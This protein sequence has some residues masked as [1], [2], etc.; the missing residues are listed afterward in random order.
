MKRLSLAVALA[1]LVG[2]AGI[3]IP[4]PPGPPS[5]EPG[6][7]PAPT[8]PAGQHLE[9]V[10]CV[11]DAP[12]PVCNTPEYPKACDCW[13][14][15]PGEP[16][17]K[18]AACAGAP[19][20]SLDE[21][22]PEKNAL[23]NDQVSRFGADVL[24]AQGGACNVPPLPDWKTYVKR[25]QAALKA[26]GYHTRYDWEHGG[27]GTTTGGED[28]GTK[29]LGSEIGIWT[30]EDA[31]PGRAPFRYESYQ[32]V[33]TAPK[34][35]CNGFTGAAAVRGG[36][37]PPPPAPGAECAVPASALDPSEPFRAD[38]KPHPPAQTLD[39]TLWGCGPDVVAK[40]DPGH[41]PH[42]SGAHGCL[43][44]CCPFEEDKGT[45]PCADALWG[46]ALWSVEE[47]DAKLVPTANTNTIKVAAGSGVVKVCGS[48]APSS[49]SCWKVFGVD[50]RKT[51][52]CTVDPAS[53]PR[54]PKCQKDRR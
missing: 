49:K 10:A 36:A 2:C 3:K 27:T 43:D 40:L 1:L 45:G 44:R 6:P 12:S 52:I 21:P 33:T 38:V 29:G 37:P 7:G 41:V 11:A 34:I 24:T 39:I 14:K 47:G 25:V 31:P 18:T 54:D 53:D 20:A 15:P 19:Q 16:W 22:E 23:P 35:R 5:P 8:C 42:T 4:G 26:M 32:L 50:L 13:H 48:S 51:P 9:G 28:P 30:L 46:K 17:Q